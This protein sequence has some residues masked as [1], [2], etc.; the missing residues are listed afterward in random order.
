M[1]IVIGEMIYTKYQWTVQVRF[2]FK[3]FK[4]TSGCEEC[5]GVA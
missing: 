4:V 2:V 1:G 3:Q 5:C